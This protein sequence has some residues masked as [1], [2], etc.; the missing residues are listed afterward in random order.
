MAGCRCASGRGH[1]P[2]DTEFA[3]DGVALAG[4]HLL[5]KISSNPIAHVPIEDRAGL[6][7][8]PDRPRTLVTY[9]ASLRDTAAGNR[10]RRPFRGAADL[11]RKRAAMSERRAGDSSARS[12][13]RAR[14]PRPAGGTCR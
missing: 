8:A 14:R 7:A 2:T 6:A 13:A 5:E 11:V 10:P 1:S 12:I 4:D 9:L 3:A